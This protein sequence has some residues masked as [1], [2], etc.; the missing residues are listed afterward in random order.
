MKR[1]RTVVAG[2]LVLGLIGLGWFVPRWQAQR[3]VD[4]R[5]EQLCENLRTLAKEHQTPYPRAVFPGRVALAEGDAT[6]IYLTLSDDGARP[7]GWREAP[8]QIVF[9]DHD[10]PTSPEAVAWAAAVAPVVSR[11]VSATARPS[12]R[13]PVVVPETPEDWTIVREPDWSAVTQ[14]CRARLIQARATNDTELLRAALDVLV[15][16]RDLLLFQP[17]SGTSAELVRLA[18]EVV[19]A[20]LSRSSPPVPSSPRCGRGPS[21]SPRPPRFG[22]STS[23]GGWS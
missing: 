11:R 21:C 1:Y 12:C 15:V 13:W 9:V 16:V 10:P 19:A 14:V 6:D 18:S 5:I 17:I 4:A 3:S 23:A 8:L 7:D 2:L 22:L 20:T